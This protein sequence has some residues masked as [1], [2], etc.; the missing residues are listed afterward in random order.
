MFQTRPLLIS[1][2]VLSVYCMKNMNEKFDFVI[3]LK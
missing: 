1:L 2:F 3:E